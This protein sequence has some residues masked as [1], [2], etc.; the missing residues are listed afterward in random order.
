MPVLD[1]DIFDVHNTT[2]RQ[3]KEMGKAT[4]IINRSNLSFEE[5]KR[6]LVKI[7]EEINKNADFHVY[8]TD[9]RSSFTDARPIIMSSGLSLVIKPSMPD[10]DFTLTIG[11]VIA[12]WHSITQAVMVFGTVFEITNKGSSADRTVLLT[13]NDTFTHPAEKY[14]IPRQPE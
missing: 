10:V 4:K 5:A 7:I 12:D 6:N 2:R 11:Q 9:K 3:G 14:R 1:N 8:I 13:K